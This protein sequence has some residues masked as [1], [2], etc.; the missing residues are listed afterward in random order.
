MFSWTPLG[1]TDPRAELFR[2]EKICN[3]AAG[4]I[5]HKIGHGI[6]LV[7]FPVMHHRDAVSERDAV[8]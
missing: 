7:E 1:E 3:V 4:R 2:L 6:D 5:A 8:C